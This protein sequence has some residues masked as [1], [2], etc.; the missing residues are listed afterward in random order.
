MDRIE[1]KKFKRSESKIFTG[2]PQGEKARAELR[3][4][5]FDKN[6]ESVDIIIPDDTFSVNSSFFLG[7]FQQSIKKLGEERFREKYRFKCNKSLIIDVNIEKNIK[8]C[9]LML[10]SQQEGIAIWK[11]GIVNQ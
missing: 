3:L 4:D 9:I 6:N 2:R 11:N 5:D 1:L 8:I 7:M 10:N